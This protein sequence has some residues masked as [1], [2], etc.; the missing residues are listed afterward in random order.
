MRIVA[1]TANVGNPE[2][3][4]NPG[5]APTFNYWFAKFD[6]PA[7]YN[8]TPFQAIQFDLIAPTGSQM[9]FTMTQKSPNCTASFQ[10]SRLVGTCY[11]FKLVLI[12]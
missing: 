8:L 10:G 9:N 1:G 4:A 12:Q 2:P 7:C 6:E 11:A 5:T 3:W